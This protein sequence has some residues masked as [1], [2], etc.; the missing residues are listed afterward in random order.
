MT[1]WEIELQYVDNILRGIDEPSNIEQLYISLRPLFH[2]AIHKYGRECEHEDLMQEMYMALLSAIGQYKDPKVRGKYDFHQVLMSNANHK[3]T[4]YLLSYYK[5]Y[6]DGNGKVRA[7]TTHCGALGLNERAWDAEDAPEI[8]DIIRAETDVESEVIQRETDEEQR[9]AAEVLWDEVDRLPSA[10]RDAVVDYYKRGIGYAEKAGET[11]EKPGTIAARAQRGTRNL[12]SNP[13]VQEIAQYYLPSVAY[14]GGLG[15]FKDTGMSSTEYVALKNIE[16]GETST[17]KLIT[18][19]FFEGK[20]SA[21]VSRYTGVSEGVIKKLRKESGG[22]YR[23]T[24]EKIVRFYDVPFDEVFEICVERAV[25][26]GNP[27][28]GWKIPKSFRL[29]Q[30]DFFNNYTKSRI[31]REK[32]KEL[33]VSVDTVD[34]SIQRLRKCGRVNTE[35]AKR[36]AYIFDVPFEMLFVPV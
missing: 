8:Q 30:T 9:A 12:R 13:R 24:A 33:N 18:P 19:S 32:V 34:N 25:P 1:T 5:Q 26:K 6:T 29:A 17:Y 27:A 35:T 10:Q 3:I 2:R 15:F 23:G 11:G 4:A 7:F 20:S 16:R 31:S 14:R 28:K 21:V 22:V 36:I